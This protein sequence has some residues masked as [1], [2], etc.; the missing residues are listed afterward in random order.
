MI[1]V[2]L[3]LLKVGKCR[4]KLPKLPQKRGSIHA[5]ADL[6]ERAAA[7]AGPE[8]SSNLHTGMTP[9]LLQKQRVACKNSREGAKW[10]WKGL[11]LPFGAYQKGP[12]TNQPTSNS[13]FEVATP[14]LLP[15]EEKNVAI[16][17]RWRQK[18]RKTAQREG[19]YIRWVKEGLNSHF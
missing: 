10:R 17:R 4:Y 3:W 7:I 12:M 11:Q 6:P 2:F 8:P 9:S 18:A 16:G 19:D 5:R 13:I 1:I 15:L 14:E